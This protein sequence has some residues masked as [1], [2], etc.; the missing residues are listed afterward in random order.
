MDYYEI[1]ENESKEKI[2]EILKLSTFILRYKQACLLHNS[3]RNLKALIYL[4]YLSCWSYI[5]FISFIHVKWITGLMSLLHTLTMMEDPFSGIEI[6]ND[7]SEYL[8][9]IDKNDDHET[10]S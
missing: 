1:I 3:L 6:F 8:I 7:L 5:L 2:N 9:K 4:G 10:I